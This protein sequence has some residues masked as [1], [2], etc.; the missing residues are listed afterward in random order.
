MTELGLNSIEMAR[1]A[2]QGFL[3][4]DKMLPAELCTEICH[5]LKKHRSYA[6][7]VPLDRLWAEEDSAIGKAL[8]LPQMQAVI[9]SLVG[10]NPRYDHHA[11]HRSRP[12]TPGQRL[13]QDA[14]YDHRQQRFDIQ[15]SIFP[16]DT[17]WQMGGTRFLP[18][19]HFRRVNESQI[20]RYHNIL[21]QQQI[22]CE[23][24]TVVFWHHNLWHSGRPNRSQEER[25]MFK[26]RLNPTV[27]QQLL[28]DCRDLQDKETKAAVERELFKMHRWHGQQRRLHLMSLS[29][30]WRYLSKDE[31]FDLHFYHTRQEEKSFGRFTPVED[32]D[33]ENNQFSFDLK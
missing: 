14:E 8:R 29:A 4:F 28:W 22:E 11:N 1:F 20:G 12:G 16:Q 2:N 19:S 23:A 13:H 24:G 5:E 18:G 9:R 25:I 31:D 3:R 15:V 17:N 7:G 6:F 33:L 26:L 32:E 10:D 27:E 21:G 30:F